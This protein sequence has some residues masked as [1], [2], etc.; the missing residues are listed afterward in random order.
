MG[1]LGFDQPWKHFEQHALATFLA[2]VVIALLASAAWLGEKTRQN[3]LS[4]LLGAAL[5]VGM[6]SLAYF[7]VSWNEIGRCLLGLVLLY[8][9]VRVVFRKNYVDLTGAIVAVLAA[10]MMARMILNGR[11]YQFGFYQAALAAV[12]IPAILIGELPHRFGFQRK[13]RVIFSIGLCALVLPGVIILTRQSIRQLQ[14]KTLA[15]GDG[16]DRFYAFPEQVEPTGEMVSVISDAL[17]KEAS[18]ETL[19]VLP[20]GVMINYLARLPSTVAPFIFFSASTKF[21]GEEEIVRALDRHPPDL[22]VIVSRDLREYGIQRYGEAPGKGALLL[23]WVDD[24]YN[25]AAHLGGDPLN[26]GERGA[27]I[28]RRR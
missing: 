14:M 28:F 25:Q 24:N 27:I 22:V 9:P 13:G 8:L 16:V 20:E 7:V 3:W 18:G 1:F 4:I 21:G 19:L 11:I 23:R 12:T 2:C 17:R 10:A 15:L 26:P 5:A 6:A